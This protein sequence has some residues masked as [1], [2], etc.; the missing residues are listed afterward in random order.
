MST[1][2]EVLKV[3][4]FHGTSTL[5]M[6]SI[7]QH[8]LG[9][10]NPVEK[11][12]LVDLSKEVYSLSEYY[13][14]NSK[15]FENRSASYKRMSEQDNGSYNFQHGDTYLS[16]SKETALD[17]AMNKTFGSEILTYTIDF[18]KELIRLDIEYVK[19][20]L[21]RRYPKVFGYI[22]ANPSPILVQA[23]NVKI[24][25]L[26][27]EYGEVPVNEFTTIEK[28]L[29]SDPHLLN[30]AL[31]QVNFRLLTPKHVDD[32]SFW[33]VNIRRWNNVLPEYNLYEI[34]PQ[35]TM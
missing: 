2:D 9:G 25:S 12:K 23:R 17:Y 16:A 14:K 34:I 28:W 10:V 35:S 1:R 5:F 3:D 21:Y 7:I 27:N 11:L 13:L 6:D 4:L 26:V 31:S 22:D 24:D 18:L 30:A 32:L 29:H 19:K 33:L 8:G 15:M 20:E